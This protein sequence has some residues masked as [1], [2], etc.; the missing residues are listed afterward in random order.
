MDPISAL[1]N[2]GASYYQFFATM[3]GGIFENIK[4]NK[5]LPQQEY[6]RLI[7]VANSREMQYIDYKAK[8]QQQLIFLALIAAAFIVAIMFIKKK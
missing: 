8:Q 3:A 1:A 5:L 2:L 7:G 4:L 6:D